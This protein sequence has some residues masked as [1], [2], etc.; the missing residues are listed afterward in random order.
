MLEYQINVAR[1]NEMFPPELRRGIASRIS[2]TIIRS[3][4]TDA[5]R[6][7][8]DKYWGTLGKAFNRY[9]FL[10]KEILLIDDLFA[11]NIA[12]LDW[13]LEMDFDKKTVIAD[14][15]CGLGNLM[16]YLRE[17]GFSEIWGYDNWNQIER[18]RAVNFL[19]SCGMQEHLVDLSTI[20]EKPIDVLA[21]ISLFFDWISPSIASLVAKT[22]YILVDTGYLPAHDIE[23][24]EVIG[25]YPKLLNV[26]QRKELQ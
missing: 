18:E 22:K 25:C 5:F 4:W 13:L 16:F 24:F 1:F 10:P 9:E 23:G 20:L 14:I 12:V 26:Y 19:E 21:C 7:F 8:R 11:P 17:M 2:A 6:A 3:N 15:P